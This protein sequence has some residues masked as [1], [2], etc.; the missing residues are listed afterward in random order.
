MVGAA[1]TKR[2]AVGAGTKRG[3]VR[4]AGTKRGVVGA[5]GTK[6]GVVGAAGTKRGRWGLPEQREEGGGGPGKENDKQIRENQRSLDRQR[7]Q[8]LTQLVDRYDARNW[9]LISRYIPGLSPQSCRLRWCN[10]LSPSIEHR[11]FSPAKEHET[12][13]ASHARH[14]NRWATVA[15]LLQGRTDNA[16]KNHWNSTLKR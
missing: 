8:V 12:I 13:L 5:A 14:G 4:A 7:R 9:S 15:K 2:G 6:R 16:M 10:Q 11:P 3:A 1:R